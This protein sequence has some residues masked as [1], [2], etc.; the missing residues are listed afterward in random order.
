MALGVADTAETVANAV[1]DGWTDGDWEA[2]LLLTVARD[3]KK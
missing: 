1:G 3:G 2:T